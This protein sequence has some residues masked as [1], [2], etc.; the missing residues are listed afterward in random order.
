MPGRIYENVFKKT[1]K[2][3]KC[4]QGYRATATITLAAVNANGAATLEDSSAVSEEVK[5]ILA[6]YLPGY[7]P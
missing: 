2:I 7:L 1:N 6:P 3:V 4:W 5:H